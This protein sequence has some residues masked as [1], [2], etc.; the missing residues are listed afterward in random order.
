M[1]IIIHQGV[2]GMKINPKILSIPPYISTSWKNIASLH[3]ENQPTVFVLVVT[4]LNGARIEVPDLEPSMIES[5]F[6]AHTR[7]MEQ[8][9]KPAQ[10]KIPPRASMSFPMGQ[11]AA[12]FFR[13]PDEKWLGR[14]G[15]LRFIITTQP[16]T[17]RQSRPPERNS[18]K[19][20]RSLQNFGD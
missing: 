13:A 17:G 7:Y 1:I 10:P 14:N 2:L 5:I 9:E 3:V 8:D 12:S 15:T 19:D 6:A 16:R 4:L 11:E 20:R 18:S